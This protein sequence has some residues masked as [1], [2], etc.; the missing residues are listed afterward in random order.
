MSTDHSDSLPPFTMGSH[1]IDINSPP[2]VGSSSM[3]NA[4]IQGSIPAD[5]PIGQSAGGFGAEALDVGRSDSTTMPGPKVDAVEFRVIRPGVPVRRLRLTGNRYTFGSAEGCSIRLNDATLRPMHAVLIRDANRV[6]VRAYS[7]PL[8]VNGNRVT[9][10]ALQIGDVMRMGAYRFELLSGIDPSTKLASAVPGSD[11]IHDPN[12]AAFDPSNPNDQQAWQSRLQREAA[13]WRIRQSEVDLRE[14]RCI[15]RETELRAREADMWSRADQLHRRETQLMSQE[16]AALQIQEEYL[17]RK[18][19]L[20]KLRDESRVQRRLLDERQDQIQNME[21]EYQQQVDNAT[22]QLEL[23]QQQAESATEAVQ[24]MREQFASLN[25]QLERLTQQQTALETS[26]H[27]HMEQHRQLQRELETARDEAVDARAQSEAQRHSAENRVAELI[28]QIETMES[29]AADNANLVSED[30]SVAAELRSQIVELEDRVRQV[31][32]EASQLREDYEGACASIRQLEL[33]V[34]QT[35]AE[36]DEARGG[37]EIESDALRHSVEQLNHDLGQANLELTELRAAN[38]ALSS[39]LTQTRE[40]RDTAVEDAQSRPTTEAFDSLRDELDTVKSRLEQ[41]QQEYDDTLARIDSQEPQQFS[42][43]V[44]DVD[45]LIDQSASSLQEEEVADSTD[46]VSSVEMGLIGHSLARMPSADAPIS[47]T[48]ASSGIETVDEVAEE[49]PTVF[50]TADAPSAD[51][52]STE[53]SNDSQDEDDSEAWPTYQSPVEKIDAASEFEPAAEDANPWQSSS[54]DIDQ[55]PSAGES[56]EDSSVAESTENQWRPDGQEQ[57]ETTGHL[58]AWDSPDAS[59]EDASASDAA[60]AAGVTPENVPVWQNESPETALDEAIADIEQNVDQAIADIDGVAADD[61]VADEVAVDE[62]ASDAV[63]GMLDENV[64][65]DAGDFATPITESEEA[66]ADEFN[67]WSS[68]VVD[69]AE[70]EPTANIWRDNEAQDSEEESAEGYQPIDPWA[71]VNGSDESVSSSLENHLGEENDPSQNSDED[72]SVGSLADMLIRDMDN[73]ASQEG[74]EAEDHSVGYEQSDSLDAFREEHPNEVESKEAESVESTFV[75]ESLLNEPD[76][77]DDDDAA[78]DLH[79]PDS[80]GAND[81]GVADEVEAESAEVAD[82]ASDDAAE[83]V[84]EDDDSIEAYMN[85]LLKRVQT[86]P[87]A[88]N[89]EAMGETKSMSLAGDTVMMESADSD[90]IV[91]DDAEPL[92]PDAPLVPRSQA[93]ERSRNM[94]AMRDLANESARSAVARSVRIQARDTQVKAVYKFLGA[95]TGLACGLLCI[96]FRE[97]LGLIWCAMCCGLGIVVAVMYGQEGMALM[98]EASTRMAAAE[99][100]EISQSDMAQIEGL[101]SDA[102]QSADAIDDAAALNTAGIGSHKAGD[103]SA[104]S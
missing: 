23:S 21:F 24:R 72:A 13:Q 6:L 100:G 63:A 60:A 28:Q 22:R 42:S 87:D 69:D 97:Q 39:D 58:S 70:P 53:T 80:V 67:P 29:A 83:A 47:D 11:T 84:S 17:A 94:S 88:S 96:Y 62:V 78:W 98:K 25:E 79:K 12:H 8:E 95:I 92:D 101:D 9:E 61:V 93:P 45:H 68:S 35:T 37:L 34:D 19:E 40:E 82:S 20:A 16:T 14:N 26:D 2:V 64:E 30:E 76:D 104:K 41:M 66:S 57:V 89:E 33:L 49:T 31:T 77:L 73:D 7:V 51:A 10:T 71:Q 18:E 5:L 86:E 50:E 59:I 85:R 52:D 27:S 103:G 3:V 1:P 38:D 43:E 74:V 15:E 75:M 46:S 81:Q 102:G 44:A 48:D 91:V 55:S 4:G 32:E 65:T 90:S 56:I 36:R 99:S 54:E